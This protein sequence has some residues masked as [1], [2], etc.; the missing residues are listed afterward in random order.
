MNTNQDA[1][2]R[3]QTRQGATGPDHDYTLP[4]EEVAEQY[5]AAGHPRTLRTIQRYCAKGDLDCR[6]VPT[7]TGEVYRVAPYSVMRHIAQ[8]NEVIAFTPAATGRDE[9]RQDALVVAAPIQATPAPTPVPTTPVEPRHDTTSRDQSPPVAADEPAKVPDNHVLD[10]SRRYVDQLEKRIEE[11][12][13]E[14]TFLK[15][16]VLAKDEQIKISNETIHSLI[17]RSRETQG[18][19]E[20]LGGLVSKLQDGFER[21]AL[22]QPR[23]DIHTAKMPSSQ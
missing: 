22:N 2:S 9:A 12:T 10:L 8:T 4:V 3:D 14:V 23:E 17:D 18:F 15:S 19:M 6:K 13:E 21:L 20:R 7:L 11:K 5:A 1:F 16:Q